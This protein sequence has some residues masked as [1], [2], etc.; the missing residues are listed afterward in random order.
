MKQKLKGRPQ[1]KKRNDDICRLF[2]SGKKS[3]REIAEQ[4][5]ESWDNIWHILKR[6]GEEWLKKYNETLIP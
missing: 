4:Y 5:G 3:V 2:Y 6:R 1:K